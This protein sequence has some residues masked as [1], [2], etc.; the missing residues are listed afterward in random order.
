MVG[1]KPKSP[2]GQKDYYMNKT[3]SMYPQAGQYSSG[4]IFGPG[5]SFT[6]RGEFAR[7]SP[8]TK[9]E[10]KLT[11]LQNWQDKY[12]KLK[13]ILEDE[14]GEQVAKLRESWETDIVAQN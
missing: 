3:H 4:V 14:I 9:L 5:H 8:A 7:I 13:N 12:K 2:S 10:K 1:T 11:S 6:M